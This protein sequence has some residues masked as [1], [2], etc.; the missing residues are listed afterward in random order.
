[1]SRRAVLLYRPLRWFSWTS[2]QRVLFRRG[3]S[4]VLTLWKWHAWVYMNLYNTP[5]CNANIV[6]LLEHCEGYV[7][8]SLEMVRRKWTRVVDVM[9]SLWVICCAGPAIGH[10]RD[11]TVKGP[12]CLCRWFR[13]AG[14]VP[15]Y[16][17][18]SRKAQRTSACARVRIFGLKL[19]T[20]SL[21]HFRRGLR[22]SIT[23]FACI[24]ALLLPHSGII[25]TKTLDMRAV[26]ARWLSHRYWS[27]LLSQTS[28]I[29]DA[30][31]IINV[32]W[33]IRITSVSVR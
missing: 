3:E 17:S 13:H 21:V 4:F 25:P 20:A 33:K 6:S 14:W 1:M 11:L 22:S 32:T 28:P 27:G 23:Y 18:G 8:W 24:I 2:F 31:M 12:S 16:A 29:T 15:Y 19:T 30:S 10:S 7:V 26:R 9:I 5:A